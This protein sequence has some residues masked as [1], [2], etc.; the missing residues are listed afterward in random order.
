MFMTGS[1]N[2]DRQIC[3]KVDPQYFLTR[4]FIYNFRTP[5]EKKVSPEQG[6]PDNPAPVDGHRNPAFEYESGC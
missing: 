4:L 1:H 5:K 2:Q 3:H 6:L